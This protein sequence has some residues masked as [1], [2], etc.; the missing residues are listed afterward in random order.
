STAEEEREAA[1]RFN[2]GAGG[3]AKERQWGWSEPRLHIERADA[4]APQLVFVRAM[5]MDP[6]RLGPRR[7]RAVRLENLNLAHPRVAGL[8]VPAPGRAHADGRLDAGAAAPV[9]VQAIGREGFREGSERDR[10]GDERSPRRRRLRR[11]AARAAVGALRGEGRRSRAKG[12]G[13]E[14]QS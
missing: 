10:P 14:E 12:Q 5:A 13:R 7:R 2:A 11:R 1:V 8:E 9:V 3:D 4:I 6:V